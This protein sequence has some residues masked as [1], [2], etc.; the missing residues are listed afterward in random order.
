MDAKGHLWHCF[1]VS[2]DVAHH[3]NFVVPADWVV[4]DVR[5]FRED[6][7]GGSFEHMCRN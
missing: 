2:A 6:R 3:P 5:F 7:L 4:P 1:P